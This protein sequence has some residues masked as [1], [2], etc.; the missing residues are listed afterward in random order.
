MFLQMQARYLVRQVHCM[1]TD[2]TNI[3]IIGGNPRNKALKVILRLESE[4]GVGQHQVGQASGSSSGQ[5]GSLRPALFS[6]L[7]AHRS[8]QTWVWATPS[9][10]GNPPN[11]ISGS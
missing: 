7:R 5:S 2:V 3:V 10:A 6:Q 9:P 11:G 1:V 4:Y 8:R